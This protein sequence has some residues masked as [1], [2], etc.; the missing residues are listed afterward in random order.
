MIEDSGLIKIGETSTLILH[1]CDD[2]SSF[3][4]CSEQAKAQRFSQIE[5]P[6]LRLDT[7]M[8]RN[9]FGQPEIVRIDADSLDLDVFQGAADN[10]L[11]A[12][13]VSIE[14]LVS[15]SIIPTLTSR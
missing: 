3:S 8:K 10:L 12:D 7:Y 13:V 15:N 1:A 2:C 14:T 4:C 9:S 11:Q 6:F 5:I